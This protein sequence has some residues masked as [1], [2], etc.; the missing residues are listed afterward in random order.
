MIGIEF[1]GLGEIGHRSIKVA[2]AGAAEGPVVVGPPERWIEFDGRFEMRQRFARLLGVQNRL[3]KTVVRPG[4][5]LL[6]IGRAGRS[7]ARI[8]ALLAQ[9]DHALV[10]LRRVGRFA[11]LESFQNQLLALFRVGILCRNRGRAGGKQQ[12]RGKAADGR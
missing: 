11:G 6:R 7:G 5:Q 12:Q 3:A 10:I 4:H 2:G 9:L 1:D 8:D